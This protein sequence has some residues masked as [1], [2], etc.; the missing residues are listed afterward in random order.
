MQYVIRT[1]VPSDAE[2]AS[3][4]VALSFCQIA[5]AD[6][7][8]RA[9]NELLGGTAPVGLADSIAT[10]AYAAAAFDG[11]EVLGFLHRRKPIVVSTLFVHPQWVRRGI[12]SGLWESARNHVETTFPEVTTVELNATPNAIPFYLAVGFMPLSGEITA[13]GYRF[14]RMACWLPARGFVRNAL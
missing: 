4:L 8:P 3:R 10:A 14:T 11:A 1:A 6:W 9:R 13:S 7:E 12:A 5:A 2:A